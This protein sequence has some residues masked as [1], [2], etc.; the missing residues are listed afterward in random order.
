MRSVL[1]DHLGR[2]WDAR[3]PRLAEHLGSSI[4][5]K[6]LGEYVVRNMGYVAAEASD[7]SIHVRLRPAIAAAGAL[8]ALLSWLRD[9]P[10]ERV[11][12]STLEDGWRHELMP[13]HQAM[14]HISAISGSLRAA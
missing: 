7:R 3:S 2:V 11:L 14:S 5:G 12:I 13:M 8:R 4:K 1:F 6:A 9:K 10:M